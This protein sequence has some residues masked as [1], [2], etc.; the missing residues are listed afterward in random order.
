MFT[1]FTPL[2]FHPILKVT[3][4]ICHTQCWVVTDYMKKD[5][6]IRFQKFCICNYIVLKCSLLDYF[7]IDDMITCYSC[8]A[9]A[10]NYS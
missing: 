1:H 7:F 2:Q 3:K 8:D 9:M 10:L 4:H 5:Y 6:V